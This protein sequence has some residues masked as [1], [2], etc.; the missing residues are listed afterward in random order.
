MNGHLD[1]LKLCVFIRSEMAAI[2]AQYM[3]TGINFK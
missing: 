3:A 1:D 2:G